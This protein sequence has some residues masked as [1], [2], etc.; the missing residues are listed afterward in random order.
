MQIR[1]ARRKFR[2]SLIAAHRCNMSTIA[3]FA[4]APARTEIEPLISCV[5][6]AEIL[7]TSVANLGQMRYEHRGPVYVRFG[8]K[9]AYLESDLRTYIQERRV[10]PHPYSE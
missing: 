1:Q 7:L 5:T 10:Q 2:L 9:I 8:R 3:A 4:E 6:A